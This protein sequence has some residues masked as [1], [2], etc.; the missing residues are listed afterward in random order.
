MANEIK[1][2]VYTLKI[3]ESG[4]KKS[5]LPL[6]KFFG[7][8]DFLK[9]FQ[10]YIK[11][12][13]HQLELN[14]NQKRSLKLD[15]ENLIVDTAKRMISG[16]IESGDYGYESTLVNIKTGKKKYDR[17]IDDTEIKPFY[18]LIY[19]PKNTAVGYVILQRLGVYGIHSIFKNHITD[20]FKLR[21]ANLQ[22]ELS[23]FISK[24][25]A[26]TFIEKGNIRELILL[27]YNLPPDI[28]EKIGM[29]DQSHDIKSI[30]LHIKARKKS[31]LAINDGL[32]KF[33]KDANSDFFEVKELEGIGF[34]GTH[35]IKVRSK[36]NG[37]TRTI[38]LSDTGQIRPYYDVDNKI[39]KASSGHPIF[40][41]IDEVAKEL[42]IEL[43]N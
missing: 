21:F 12:F 4:N 27:R 38:D 14:E 8:S 15:S 36:Y 22:L 25:L 6:E 7:G 16:I 11:S 34:D 1:L 2:E 18:F 17:T 40:D 39:E 29:K 28:A 23:Q 41:S 32:K 3:R 20:F 43:V 26:N 35:K 33:V 37:T 24:E 9:F 13:D 10:D 19:L 31:R 30:E 5:F 42:V